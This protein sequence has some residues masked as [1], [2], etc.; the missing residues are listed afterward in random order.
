[1]TQAIVPLVYFYCWTWIG[2]YRLGRAEAIAKKWSH[3]YF[4]MSSANHHQNADDDIK[5]CLSLTATELQYDS[6]WK[7]HDCSPACATFFLLDIPLLVRVVDG[8]AQYHIGCIV[9]RWYLRTKC[10][11]NQVSKQAGALRKRMWWRT[12]NGTEWCEH[13]QKIW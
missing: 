2:Q 9:Y 11:C 4:T 6:C 13:K 12:G 3:S 1:M 10:L 5:H 7:D 8:Q